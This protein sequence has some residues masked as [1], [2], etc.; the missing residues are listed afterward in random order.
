[1]T[2]CELFE[3]Y[4]DDDLIE[5]AEEIIKVS[6]KPNDKLKEVALEAYKDTYNEYEEIPITNILI[7]GSSLAHVLA[8]RLETKK[9]MLTNT[10]L[11]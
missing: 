6:K 2:T 11:L 4:S 5:M 3:K 10:T 1:M 9:R 8:K 7:L